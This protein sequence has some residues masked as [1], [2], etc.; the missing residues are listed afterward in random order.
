MNAQELRAEVRVPVI[1]RGNLG[2]GSE[3]FS[4]MV[5]DMSS[6]GLLIVSTRQLAAGQTLEFKCELYPG[7]V[8]DCMIEVMHSDEDSAG[9]MIT[10]IDETATKLLQG[11]LEERLAVMLDKKP[12]ARE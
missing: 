10:G 8:F 6:S 4:C 5:M 7:K 11:Y 12:V 3:W 1:H 2:T 9:A